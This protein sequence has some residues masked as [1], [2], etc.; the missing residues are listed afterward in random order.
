MKREVNYRKR[1]KLLKSNL[2]R[3]VVRKT[4]SRIIIQIIEYGPG[5]DKTLA[6]VYSDEL[7]KFGWELGIKNIPAAYLSGLLIGKKSSAREAILDSGSRTLKK[8]SFIYFAVR[9][10]Q[11]AGLNLHAGE[12]PLDNERIF[13]AHISSYAASS[14]EKQFSRI[15]S[16]KA[17]N[18]KEYVNKSIEKINAY[19]K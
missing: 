11:E 16:E 9:G 1:L 19:G 4:D 5:G 10:A 18:I 17:K 13:G 6:S 2:P 14:K 7:R 8:D 15:T 3:F 12:L